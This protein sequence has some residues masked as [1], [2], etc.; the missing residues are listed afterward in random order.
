MGVIILN[1]LA[2][3]LTIYLGRQQSIH[4]ES[5]SALRVGLIAKYYARI[6]SNISLVAPSQVIIICIFIMIDFVGSICL[7]TN[8]VI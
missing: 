2:M 8:S 5:L 1:Y 6:N 4:T 7:C 3:I